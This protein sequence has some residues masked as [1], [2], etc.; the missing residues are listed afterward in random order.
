MSKIK[1]NF[2][3]NNEPLYSKKVEPSENLP[4]LRNKYN[5]S[6]DLIFIT[7]D[8]Y[9]ILNEDE[10]D[11]T[12]EACL[13]EGNKVILKEAEKQKEQENKKVLNT[14]IA[15]SK[16]LKNKNN[17]DLYLYPTVELTKEEEKN[18]IVLMVVGQTGSGK[19]TLLNAYINYLMGINYEDNFRY[20]II[21][22][23]FNK[24]Q[25]QSQTTEV[26]IYNVKA[27]DGTIIQI[28]D[29]PGFGD[30]GG[31]K[32][33]IEITQKIRQKF[34]DELSAITCICFVAQ[35]CNARLSANQKYIFNCILDLFGDDVKSNFKCMLTFCDLK[36]ILYVC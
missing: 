20:V 1:V 9:D 29:T 24:K 31:I 36:V 34:I 32:K 19:T 2:L 6:N 8:G 10:K 14:P 16:F 35:S 18:S 33:D 15:E 27:P 25:D 12:V 21:N 3:V 7:N 11:Y 26:T 5:I 30:T 23:E 17:L 28:I 22:E 13:T 4:N